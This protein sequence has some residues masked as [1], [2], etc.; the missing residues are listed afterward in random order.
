MTL[1]I[2]WVY[3]TDSSLRPVTLSNNTLWVLSGNRY[4]IKATKPGW[5]NAI[6][7]IVIFNMETQVSPP[8]MVNNTFI[9][10]LMTGTGEGT[11][12]VMLRRPNNLNDYVYIDFHVVVIDGLGMIAGDRK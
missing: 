2:K 9:Q 12:R 4:N 10:G 6:Q 1:D 8:L 5:E 7:E 3:P 11:V